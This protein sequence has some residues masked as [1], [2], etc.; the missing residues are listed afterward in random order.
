MYDQASQKDLDKKI[1]H[2]KEKWA[3]APTMQYASTAADLGAQ[4]Y[5]MM[6]KN[7]DNPWAGLS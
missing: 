3:S 2:Y 4:F 6:F 7:E 5:D 1:T